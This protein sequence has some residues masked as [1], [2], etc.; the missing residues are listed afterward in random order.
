MEFYTKNPIGF[1]VLEGVSRGVR[2]GLPRGLPDVGG[3]WGEDQNLLAEKDLLFRRGGIGPLRWRSLSKFSV[4]L[5][6]F[7]LPL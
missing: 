3:E 1:A 5:T 6:L 4:P 2:G 7:L